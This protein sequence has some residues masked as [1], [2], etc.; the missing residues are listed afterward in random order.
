MER[1][2]RKDTRRA[3]FR[4]HFTE[5]VEVDQSRV[6]TLMFGKPALTPA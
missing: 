3:K 1:K 5:G 6:G 4:N 2:E